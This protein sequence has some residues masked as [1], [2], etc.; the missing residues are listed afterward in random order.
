MT[1]L[2]R[3]ILSSLGDVGL[4]SSGSGRFL[5]PLKTMFK[6]I[7]GDSKLKDLD[8]QQWIAVRGSTVLDQAEFGN[9]FEETLP[10]YVGGTWLRKVQLKVDDVNV[11]AQFVNL[12]TPWMLFVRKVVGS[13]AAHLITEDAG[14]GW[15]NIGES[16][17]A[18]YARSGIG[19]QDLKAIKALIDEF[20]TIKDAQNRLANTS[21]WDTKEIHIDNEGKVTLFDRGDPIPKEGKRISG[22]YLR[23]DYLR[24]INRMAGQMFLDPAMGDRPFWMRTS[25]GRLFSQFQ[26]FTYAAAERWVWPMVQEM[27]LNAAQSRYVMS[28]AMVIGLSYFNN[29]ARATLDDKDAAEIR[30]ESGEDIWLAFQNAMRRSPL[31]VGQMSG[32]IEA[33]QGLAGKTV[34]DVSGLAVF[35]SR[36]VKFQHGQGLVGL[37]GPLFGT[38][39]RIDGFSRRFIQGDFEEGFTGMSK[40]TP[41]LGSIYAQAMINYLK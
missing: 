6:G 8:E 38:T 12:S 23:Q 25:A 14:K 17:R 18:T 13:Q 19:E 4:M 9:R 10:H 41:L 39:N 37:M 21:K 3:A 30:M 7:V 29:W 34:N 24:T 27:K 15:K 11:L 5:M 20:G 22:E 40:M 31:M 35:D 33:F 28:L 2:N 16:V 32:I 36:S 1:L 26:S